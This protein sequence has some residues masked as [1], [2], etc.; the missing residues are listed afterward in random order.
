MTY[1]GM[2]EEIEAVKKV[3]ELQKE[4][5][6]IKTDNEIKDYEI[7]KLKDKVDMLQKQK[8]ILQNSIRKY[9]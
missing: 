4:L 1:E 5:D 7:R 8:K 9:G 6:I 2:L 3:K